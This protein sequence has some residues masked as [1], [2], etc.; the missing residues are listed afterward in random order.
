MGREMKKAEIIKQFNRLNNK[1]LQFQ[2][3]LNKKNSKQEVIRDLLTGIENRF[4]LIK[5]MLE[6]KQNGRSGQW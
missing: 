6:E 3:L 2:Q 1:F 4:I 5:S